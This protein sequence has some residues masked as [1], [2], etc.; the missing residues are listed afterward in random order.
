MYDYSNDDRFH[1]RKHPRLKAY[2]YT[3][4]GFYFITIC[5][6]EKKCFFGNPVVLNQY[7]KIVEIELMEITNHYS[8]IRIDKYVIMPNHIHFIV[9]ITEDGTDLL[10]I[11]GSFKSVV[12]R[13]IHQFEPKLTLWQ[14]SFHDH[15][16]R[17]Q[18]SYE[19]IWNYIDGNPSKWE[20]DCFYPG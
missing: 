3:Q 19:R 17:N 7:G 14:T 15:V 18:K 9:E 13:K 11:I 2:N 16:I 10:N 20:E 6:N 8:G 1:K 5:T 4:R 12:T